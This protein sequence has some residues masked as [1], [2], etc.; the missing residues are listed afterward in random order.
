[1]DN[2]IVLATSN[3]TVPYTHFN[4]KPV[5]G[6]GINDAN[7]PTTVDGKRLRTYRTW[8]NM[9]QRC[10]HDHLQGRNTTYKD[11]TVETSWLRFSVFEQWMLTQDFY[12]NH[13]DKDLL[14]PGNKVYS[15]H[16]FVFVPRTLNN[17][18]EDRRAT[19][20]NLPLGVSYHKDARKRR[21]AAKVSVQDSTLNLG[22]Y[23]TPLEAHQAWQRAKADIIE[24]FPAI[25]PR[26][27]KALNLRVAQLRD[28]LANSRI[29]TSL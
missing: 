26:I 11:C 23:C 6:I 28:D 14:V 24:R 18:F 8:T 29:T 12:G 1:M 25:D 3:I 21:Y 5:F 22:S 7:H 16:I 15:A 10:Y 4:R 20:G 27:R 2:R 13:L 19:R 17:L 9:L